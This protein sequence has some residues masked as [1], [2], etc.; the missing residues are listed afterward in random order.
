M[1][2]RQI[3]RAA[4]GAD[5]CLEIVGHISRSGSEQ[6]NHRLSLARATAVRERIERD[7]P[8]ASKKWKVTGVGYRENIIGTGSDDERDAIDRRASPSG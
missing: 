8:G 6:V 3:A 4:Q 2:L 1:W 5:A 7:A